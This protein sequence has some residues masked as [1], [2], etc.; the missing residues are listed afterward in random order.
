L[1]RLAK[2]SQCY[3]LS[4]LATTTAE[5]CVRNE[6]VVFDTKGTEMIRYNNYHPFSLDGE[7]DYYIPG[8]RIPALKCQEFT[9]SPF[10]C[11]D[12]RFPEAFRVAVGRGTKLFVV[13]AKWPRS[14]HGHWEILLQA[15]AIEN[16]ALVI[17]VNRCGSDPNHSYSGGSMILDPSGN[18]LALSGYKEAVIQAILDYSLLVDYRARFPALSDQREDLIASLRYV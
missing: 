9:V 17:G 18:S 2:E 16:Q 3:V 7:N 5:G 8:N 10:I 15:C 11:D 1:S 12:L 4:G 13:I 6:A 14:R